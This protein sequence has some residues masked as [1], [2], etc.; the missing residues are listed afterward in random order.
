M[1]GYIGTIPVPQATQNREAF[2][3]TSNQTSFAT[4]GYTPGF[5]DVYLNGVK[6]A[7]ADY[8]ATNGSDVVLA[9]GA[10]SGDILEIVAFSAFTV[11]DQTF[12]GTTT[13]NNLTV[14]GTFTSRGIDDNATST[15]MTLDSSGEV[16]IGTS[17]PFDALHV[18]GTIRG[19]VSSASDENIRLTTT[20]GGGFVIDVD[21]AT[22]ANP[23]WSIRTFASEPLAFDIGGT[24]RMRIDT[25]GNLLVGTTTILAA[26]SN[27]EGISL[28]AGSY[29]GLLSVSRDSN[30]AATFNRKTLDGDI[31]EFRK[32]GAPV[33]SIG[34]DASD[35][36][37]GTGA[38]GIRFLDG[39]PSLAPHNMTTNDANDSAIDIGRSSR[40]FKDL[41]LSGGVY[42]GGTDAANKLD[43]YEIGSFTPVVADAASG[44]N[45]ATTLRSYGYYT[46]I[47]RWVNIV[48]ELT[49]IDTTGLTG[50]NNLR[51]TG[52]PFAADSVTGAVAWQGA[53]QV[54]SVDLSA[55]VPYIIPTISENADT[56]LI[57]EWG[58]NTGT[59]S[60]LINQLTSGSADINITMGYQV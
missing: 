3:A 26:E 28:A 54:A 35:L 40:R 59:D 34:T 14:T 16:G 23:T 4:L 38:A 56:I 6:L 12:T 5:I 41:Y 60:L 51:I 24:E 49:N 8:T 31:V 21:D 22:V 27:V 9:S 52:L 19:N 37:I 57:R 15:A 53:I 39:D 13:A 25:S 50:T 17:S 10:A 20:G 46:K 55:V 1:A 44:G 47:G 58:D 45:E 11:A 32:D 2:T 29:G 7:A 30:R 18:E 36:T 43:D 33:G 48:I 42:L